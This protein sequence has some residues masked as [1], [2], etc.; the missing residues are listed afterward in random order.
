M[1]YPAKCPKCATTLA[2]PDSAPGNPVRCPVCDSR[3]LIQGNRLAHL[4]FTDYYMLLGVPSTA[5]DAD[6]RKAI[7]AKIL[8]CHPD[9]NPDD[10]TAASR[11]REVL[12]AKELLT[13]PEKRRMYDGVFHAQALPRWRGRI[14]REAPGRAA[15]EKVAPP[16][17]RGYEEMVS[18]ARSRSRGASSRSVEELLGELE[19]VLRRS[20]VAIDLGGRQ[21]APELPRWGVWGAV[22]AVLFGLVFGLV[23][24]AGMGASLAGVLIMG[25]LGA[26]GAWFLASHAGDILA[27]AFFAARVVVMSAVLALISVRLGTGGW[28]VVSFFPIFKL[29]TEAALVGGMCLGLFRIGV[30]VV[31][32]RGALRDLRRL[33]VLGQAALGAWGGAL[34]GMFMVLL[35][36]GEKEGALAVGSWWFLFFSIYVFIDAQVFA[37]PH[38]IV[39]TR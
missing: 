38:I 30:S 27:L 24:G 34:V 32:G 31:E 4:S 13:D 33:L 5:G 26:L 15:W 22:V 35:M 3:F 9:R 10:P 37:R 1:P 8:E 6:V 19:E 36:H 16:P 20:G 25:G 17:D 39:F 14:P 23:L 2:F 29:L 11:L 18:G 7:R 28:D 21:G 12:Q